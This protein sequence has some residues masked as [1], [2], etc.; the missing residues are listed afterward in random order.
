LRRFG[1]EFI[2]RD[3]GKGS[4]THTGEAKVVY[5]TL[6]IVLD[7]PKEAKFPVETPDFALENTISSVFAQNRPFLMRILNTLLTD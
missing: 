7:V 1:C 6:D 4:Y 2:G 5:K 3:S